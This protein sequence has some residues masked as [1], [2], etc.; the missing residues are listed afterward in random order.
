[1]NGAEDSLALVRQFPKEANQVPRTDLELVEW[2]PSN[3]H[4]N[5]PLRVETR[6]RFVQE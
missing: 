6:S 4:G 2:P 1:M 3:L 5:V